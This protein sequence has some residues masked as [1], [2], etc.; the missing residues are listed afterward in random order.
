MRIIS[1]NFKGKKFFLPE[2]KNT[3]PLR[4]MVKESIFNLLQHSKKI[5]L[6]I[7][8]SVILDLFSGSG[9]FGIECISRRAKKVFFVENYSKAFKILKK[10]VANFNI[11]DQCFVL[12]E[13]CFKINLYEKYLTKKL[14]IIFMDPPYKEKKINSLIDEIQ[15]KKFLNKNGIIIIH[16][17]K[18]DDIKISN[19]LNILDQRTYGKSK[20]IIGN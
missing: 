7:E 15:D 18:K 19:K 1:G 6:N 9:S 3:R 10:N 20:I 8:N 11:I 13:D 16:R 5:H 2:D 17:N 12:N 14:D 4:D